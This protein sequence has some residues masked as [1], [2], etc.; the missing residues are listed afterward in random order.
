MSELL[1][2]EKKEEK[3]AVITGCTRGIGAAMVELFA[4]TGYDIFACARKDDEVYR[5]Y[6]SN[7]S[8][9]TGQDIIPVF[10]DLSDE[11]EIKRGVKEILSYKKTINVLINNAGVAHTGTLAMTPVSTMKSV[12]DVNV[13]APVVLMQLLSRHMI[14]NKKGC[15][16]NMC[17]AGGIETNPGYLAYGSGK[18]AL[19]WITRSAA[20]ELGEYGIR[21]NGIAPGLIDTDMGHT[22]S[23]EEIKKVLDRMVI[24]RMG[25]P[26]EVAKLA[27]YLAS[28]D[29]SYITGQIISIDGGR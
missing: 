15:I 20:K 4:E 18:A 14:K 9:R 16:I 21:V 29:A 25:S 24:K 27:L 7:L 12:Y 19:A 8:K 28:E 26:R 11:T 5:N 3:T 17:S 23:E 6:L 13:F 10:F 2:E 1:N 22:K